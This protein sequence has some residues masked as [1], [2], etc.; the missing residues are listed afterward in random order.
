[1]TALMSVEAGDTD[2][3]VASIAECEAL[4]IK[5]L[6]PDI[7]ESRTDFTVVDIPEDQ[8]LPDGRAKDTG[9]A[10]RFGLSASKMLADSGH[11]RHSSCP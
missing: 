11:Y 1:M 7:N 2:K 5:V 8:R 3:V 4:G 9:K 10:I 6:A